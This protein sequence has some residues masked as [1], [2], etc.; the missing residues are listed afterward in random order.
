MATTILGIRH[1]GV[2]SAKQVLARLTMLKPDLIIVEG[3]PEIA[4]ALKYVGHKDLVPPVS[5]MVY[6]TNNPKLSSFYPFTNFSPEWVAAKYANENSIPIRTIDMPAAISF[7]QKNIVD[8]KIN[9]EEVLQNEEEKEAIQLT[10]NE[11]HKTLYL[12]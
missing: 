9:E 6:D 10:E 11:F 4:E 3:P 8:E 5:I 2:G 1:H 12:N 7:Y